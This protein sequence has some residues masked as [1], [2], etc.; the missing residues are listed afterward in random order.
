MST[1]KAMRQQVDYGQIRRWRGNNRGQILMLGAVLAPIL[2]GC[3][4]LA[5]DVGY[6]YFEK[7]RKALIAPGGIENQ[8]LP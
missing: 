6:L 3:M 7:R 8:P 4:G 1:V 2:F 5:L